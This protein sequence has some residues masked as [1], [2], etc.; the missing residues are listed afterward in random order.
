MEPQRDGQPGLEPSGKRHRGRTPSSSPSV[1]ARDGD[2]WQHSEVLVVERDQPSRGTRGRRADQTVQVSDAFAQSQAAVPT[3]GKLR[4]SLVD[5]HDAVE[6]KLP[7]ENGKLATIATSFDE[8][9]DRDSGDKAVFER[10]PAQERA[11]L[12]R[13]TQEIDENGGVDDHGAG[14]GRVRRSIMRRRSSLTKATG[15]AASGRDA[16]RPKAGCCSGFARCAVR[17]VGVASRCNTITSAS[18]GSTS[19]GT[20]S[21]TRRLRGTRT[22]KRVAARFSPVPCFAVAEPARAPFIAGYLLVDLLA[23][24]AHFVEATGSR[25]SA[26]L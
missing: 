5:P 4:L 20:A 22:L 24:L 23:Y 16:Q 6:T 7:L 26:F 18:P 14:R 8:F 13:S 1:R 15:S 2:P 11:R 9:R 21:V 25:T 19:A 17:R 10:N 3:V 12:A